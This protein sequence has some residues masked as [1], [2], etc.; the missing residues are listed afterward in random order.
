MITWNGKLN[1]PF[2]EKVQLRKDYP[3]LKPVWRSEV[4]NRKIQK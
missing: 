3:K 2:E 4:G 1:L